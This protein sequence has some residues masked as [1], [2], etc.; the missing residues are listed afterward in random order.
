MG[1]RGPGAKPA[2]AP[3]NTSSTPPRTVQGGATRADRLTAWIESLSVTS[4]AHA[5]RPLVMRPW[6]R[7]ILR[8]LSRIRNI[9]NPVGGF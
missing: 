4:G 6:Q 1:K 5:G 8:G 3:A 2:R 7:E 9:V